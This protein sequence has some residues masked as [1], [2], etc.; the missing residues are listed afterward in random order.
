[1]V[2]TEVRCDRCGDRI[3]AD[4]SKLAIECGPFHA[5][6]PIDLCRSCMEHV[7][8]IVASGLDESAESTR[9]DRAPQ[10][11]DSTTPTNPPVNAEKAPNRPVAAR[12]ACG[13]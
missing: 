3:D 11:G 8:S 1:M 9:D 12:S 5:R 4:R 6:E 7:L 13:T 10:S 2:I